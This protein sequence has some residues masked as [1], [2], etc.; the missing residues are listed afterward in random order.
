MV[1]LVVMNAPIRA[2]SVSD[3]ASDRRLRFRLGQFTLGARPRVFPAAD[4][5]LQDLPT[6]AADGFALRLLRKILDRARA[7]GARE[8]KHAEVLH[9]APFQLLGRAVSA[10]L[11]VAAPECLR[12]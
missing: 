5:P 4:A 10:V 7:V 12:Q 2:G 1:S 8:Q 3:G 6:Q 9:A 11:A